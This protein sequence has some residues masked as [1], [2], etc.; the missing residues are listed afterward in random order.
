[1]GNDPMF[2]FQL[3]DTSN[4]NSFLDNE[5][6]QRMYDIFITIFNDTYAKCL[7]AIIPIVWNVQRI[8]PALKGRNNRVMGDVY[9]WDKSPEGHRVNIDRLLFGLD[10][11]FVNDCF[12]GILDKLII[13]E[14]T[15][16]ISLTDG[17][18]FGSN[19]N[20]MVGSRVYINGE[21]LFIEAVSSDGRSFAL[22]GPIPLP[23]D[24]NGHVCKVRSEDRQFMPHIQ[25]LM[26]STS[27]DGLSTMSL[28]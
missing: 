10:H 1:M 28:V 4:P 25:S 27:L 26:E 19:L 18:E 23:L 9:P 22:S 14:A 3:Q 7:R 12:E 11:T 24:P 6:K 21:Y 17:V 8:E 15:N 5:D 2:G 16:R 13:D 20:D